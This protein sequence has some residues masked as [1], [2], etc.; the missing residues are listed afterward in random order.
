[1]NLTDIP[2]EDRIPTCCCFC[3]EGADARVRHLVRGFRIMQ[4]LDCGMVYTDPRVSVRK[5]LDQVYV[6]GYVGAA[7]ADADSRP[8]L[9]RLWRSL[10]WGRSPNAGARKRWSFIRRWAPPGDEVHLLDV[11]CNTGYA[12]ELI[13]RERP[14]WRVVGIEPS[15]PFAR[16]ARERGLEV[17]CGFLEDTS[18]EDEF[19]LLCAWDVI[20][21]VPEPVGF[22]R[23]LR[24]V[25]R[26]GGR[27][28][29]HC[30]NYLSLRRRR[31][32]HGWKILG[33]PQHLHHFT[34]T[35]L[36]RL[37]EQEH[38][39]ILHLSAG[40]LNLATCIHAVCTWPR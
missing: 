39:R 11:G 16:A 14:G 15:Q 13:A 36:R 37:L 33:P 23:A 8:L 27:A 22:V 29:L 4:C 9:S 20:E 25:L 7:R 26:P 1:M 2:P 19:D 18:W 31:Q 5:M 35:T 10:R 30:P 17:R 34:P 3:G 12:T 38:A 32:G 28:I 40:P 21:H 24:R 6:Q